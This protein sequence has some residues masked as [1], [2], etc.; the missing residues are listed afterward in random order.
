MG[1]GAPSLAGVE[2]AAASQPASHAAPR[3][4]AAWRAA[5]SAPATLA[6]P[7][8]CGGACVGTGTAASPAEDAPASE[9]ELLRNAPSEGFDSDGG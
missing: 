1:G 2:L 5:S 6:P 4:A 3:A 7:G 8:A 9:E